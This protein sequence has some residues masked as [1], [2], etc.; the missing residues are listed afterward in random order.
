VLA[1]AARPDQF[2]AYRGG[3]LG[4][5]KDRAEAVP[6]EVLERGVECTNEEEHPDLIVMYNKMNVFFYSPEYAK[7]LSEWLKT[8]GHDENTWY[9]SMIES[10]AWDDLRQNSTY[11]VARTSNKFA[12]IAERP[13]RM[14]W[15]KIINISMVDSFEHEGQ[16]F[17]TFFLLQ[18]GICF[19]IPLKFLGDKKSIK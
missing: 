16:S 11:E 8:R 13:V 17:G 18:G 12:S 7:K 3:V 10:K 1:F 2:L 19:N 14:R 4:L 5:T 9:D 15:N 6:Y